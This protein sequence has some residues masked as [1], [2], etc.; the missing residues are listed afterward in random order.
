MIHPIIGSNVEIL[1]SLLNESA[2]EQDKDVD[3]LDNANCTPLH[4][5]SCVGSLEC[6]EALLLVGTDITRKDSGHLHH[7]PSLF[8]SF[9]SSL[10]SSQEEPALFIMRPWA[11]ILS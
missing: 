2:L 9:S 4:I 7:F 5:A 1:T 6:A 3:V 8:P 10:F 11:E